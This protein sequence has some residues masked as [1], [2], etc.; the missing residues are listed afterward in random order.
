MRCA[1]P[2]ESPFDFEGQ[3]EIDNVE[4]M[5]EKEIIEISSLNFLP[6]G[7]ILRN[8]GAGIVVLV[9]YTGADTKL[10]LN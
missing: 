8:S 7:A 9:V 6:R 3:A 2:S 4:G 5:S 1:S 10:V